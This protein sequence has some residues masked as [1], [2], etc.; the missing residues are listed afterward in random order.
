[1]LQSTFLNSKKFYSPMFLIK[2][3]FKPW[4][5]LKHVMIF[6]RE[7]PKF[8]LKINFLHNYY[9]PDFNFFLVGFSFLFFLCLFSPDNFFFPRH[10]APARCYLGKAWWEDW[11]IQICL[12]KS[13]KRSR[14]E[15]KMWWHLETERIV[16]LIMG[17]FALFNR[18]VFRA[19]F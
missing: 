11:P 10:P 3:S 14:I 2:L 17:V 9:V 4:E 13:P 5:I 1:M 8:F 12:R 18:C 6:L 15:I 7:T 19:S 16:L